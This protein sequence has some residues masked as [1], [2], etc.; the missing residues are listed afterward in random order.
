MVGKINLKHT[1]ESIHNRSSKRLD[2][3]QLDQDLSVPRQPPQL[4]NTGKETN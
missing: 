4:P 2:L 3:T 1:Y